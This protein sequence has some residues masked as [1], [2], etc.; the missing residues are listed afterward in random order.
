[1]FPCTFCPTLSCFQSQDS[2]TKHLKKHHKSSSA[3]IEDFLMVY[4]I[5]QRRGDRNGGGIEIIIP[6]INN[7]EDEAFTFT[8][9]NHR[10][11]VHF[12]FTRDQ[13]EDMKGPTTD[14]MEDRMRQLLSQE[15]NLNNINNNFEEILQRDES[16]RK[17]RYFH[18]KTVELRDR[19][20]IACKSSFMGLCTQI[21]TMLNET[22]EQI[23]VLGEND[24][25]QQQSAET[26]TQIELLNLLK[27]QLCKAFL[28]LPAIYNK[29]KIQCKDNGFGIQA[30]KLFYEW[31]SM[32]K[33]E[34]RLSTQAAI[35]CSEEI[36]RFSQDLWEKII[37]MII[38][39]QLISIPYRE[40]Y[41]FRVT[42]VS[43]RENYKRKF[44]CC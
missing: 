24:E 23:I 28:S 27:E 17:D 43:L 19:I 10:R 31:I 34:G 16:I 14:Q 30:N 41:M 9:T 32:L 3:D 18:P 20:V 7:D 38:W 5:I 42:S 37:R 33:D 11:R 29:I 6:Q 15:A 22:I 39:G 2:F 40:L 1:M 4:G 21:I 36:I 26:Q 8:R 13:I 12:E 25:E 44:L 35:F